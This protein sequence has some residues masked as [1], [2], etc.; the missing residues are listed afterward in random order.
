MKSLLIRAED[1]NQ[2]ERRSA[3]IP[4]DLKKI[5]DKT[6]AQA[7]I[8]KSPKR[9]FKEEKY[10]EAGALLCEDMT[11]GDVILGVKEIPEEKI[12]NNKTYI[13]FSHTIKGQKS[14]MPLLKKIIASG[15][16]L[17]DYEKITDN[18]NRRLVY[19]GNFAGDAG[20]IDILSL[21]GEYWEHKGIKTPFSECKKAHEYKSVADAK[22]N[23]K[24]I[25][26]KIK[27][28]G[29]P[30]KISPVIIG[31]LGYGNVSKG[32]QSIL[33]NL[34]VEYIEPEAL[35]K[36]AEKSK[37]NNK[38]YVCVFK[39]KDIVK[40]KTGKSFNLQDYYE[41]P[42][43]YSSVFDKYLPYVTILINAIYWETRY[44][45]FVTW[46]ALKK[47]YETSENPKL[48]GIADI[49]CDLNGSIE[50]TVKSTDSGSP[51]F[52]C[53]PIDKTVTDGVKGDGV[54]VL[55]VDNLPCE[56]PKDSSTFFSS[57]LSP[58]IQNILEAN[59]GSSLEESGLCSEINK[60]VIVYNGALTQNYEY[61]R[62]L[63][64]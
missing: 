39:E 27:K 6:G 19:F 48:C 59:Y 31:I 57:S 56:V 28:D 53:N 33:N 34:P 46:D 4:D 3:I 62:K 29:I 9:F 49:T 32:A 52:I 36:I 37:D 30:S 7:Y 64:E 8:E 1:K 50:C 25:G 41:N 17:I 10:Q 54:L 42:G 22:K 26:E 58:F 40:T 55:A 14:G 63:V 24:L 60:A 51:S 18:K 23:M 15:S 38:I 43:N 13:F 20:A 21:M 35:K 5:I 47:L 11:S 61:L 16:T 44:P 45:R 12:L 2:W